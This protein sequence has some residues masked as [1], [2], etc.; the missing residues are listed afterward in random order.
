MSNAYR[1]ENSQ[2]TII[3]VSLAD[4]KTIVQGQAHP[5]KHALE[6]DD[7]TTGS[8]N[9]NNLGNAMLDENSVPVWLAESSD[10]SGNLVEVYANSE[11]NKIL[12]DSQ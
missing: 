8:D 3:A 5:T 1:D 7:N 2:P 11:T 12:V 10:G 9:G 6:V 4:G